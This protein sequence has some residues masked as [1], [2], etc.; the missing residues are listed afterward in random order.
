MNHLLVTICNNGFADEVMDVAK[1]AGARG[2]TILHARG[3]AEDNP[4]QFLGITI[5]PEK[6]VV[7]IIVNDETK[8]N[9]MQAI[10]T[11]LGI[12]TKAHSITFS[13][14]VDGIVG[15]NLEK[16]EIDNGIN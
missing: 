9:I 10:A 12:G 8:N 2:G 1:S 6:D 13:M 7:I 16:G 5:E 11:K 3:S 4:L 14:P 15:I